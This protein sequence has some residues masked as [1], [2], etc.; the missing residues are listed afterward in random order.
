[1]WENLNY[2][3][4][5][6][7]KKEIE[8]PIY[9]VEEILYEKEEETDKPI[10]TGKMMAGKIEA[11]VATQ[12]KPMLKREYEFCNYLNLLYKKGDILHRVVP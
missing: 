5:R 11:W 10:E 1:M 8:S 2:G 4:D 7:T 3:I 9:R 6:K 12:D